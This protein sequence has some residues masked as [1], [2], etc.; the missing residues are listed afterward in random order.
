M[1]KEKTQI[2]TKQSLA[3]KVSVIY[4]VSVGVI[5]LGLT[6]FSAFYTFVLPRIYTDTN[7][8]EN[9]NQTTVNQITK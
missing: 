2:I 6:F 5:T 1:K 9:T 4:F 7:L 8:T 3:E